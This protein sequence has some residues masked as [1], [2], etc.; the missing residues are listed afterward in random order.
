MMKFKTNKT[1]TK[2]Q[3]LLLIEICFM[4]KSKV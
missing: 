2:G 4:F 1:F 3:K